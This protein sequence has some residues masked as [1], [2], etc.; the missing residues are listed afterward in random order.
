MNFLP[1]WGARYYIIYIDDCTRHTE[2]RSP[3]TKPRE[4]ICAQFRHYKVWVK[5]RGF[6]QTVPLW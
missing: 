3:A 2:E 6:H 4:E 1:F 5:A